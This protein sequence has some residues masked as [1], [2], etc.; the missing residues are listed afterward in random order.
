MEPVTIEGF[1]GFRSATAPDAGSIRL[2]PFAE[3]RVAEIVELTCARLPHMPAVEARWVFE[4]GEKLQGRTVVEALDQHDNLVGWAVTAH[5][6][7]A[8]AG[9]S[10]L[11]VLVSAEHEG[12]GLGSALRAAVIDRVP[13]GTTMLVTGVYDDEPRSLEVARHWGFSMVEHAI[14]SELP[15]VDLPEPV[16]PDGVTL[17]EAP[18]FAFDDRDAVEGM[19]QRSQ[20]NPEAEQG[21][22]FDLAKLASFVG[23]DEVPVCVLARL[24]GVPAGITTGSVADGALTISYSGID[25]PLRGRG[26]MRLVKQRA[27]IVAALAGATVS[28]THNEEHNAGIRHVNAQLGYAVTSGT[29]RMSAPFGA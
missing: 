25:P 18:D 8:P 16:L 13:R 26:L 10:F 9:R 3:H 22:V 19:L 29:Y 23:E 12:H 6:V 5:P 24:D 15:L 2:A 14:E 28:R 27:H 1:S 21:W 7:F 4:A 20:T 17:H 11:R